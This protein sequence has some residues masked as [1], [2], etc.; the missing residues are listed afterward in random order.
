M[1][2]MYENSN[3]SMLDVLLQSESIVD[4]TER[5][6]YVSL[7]ARNDKKI[8]EDLNQAKQDVGI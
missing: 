4:F 1:K 7:I 3:I 6:Q 5:L 2:V 8:L